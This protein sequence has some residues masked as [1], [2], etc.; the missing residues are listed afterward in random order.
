MR[1]ILIIIAVLCIFA[2]GWYANFAF[3][4]SNLEIP[5]SVN[6]SEQPSPK[7]RISED[8]IR[9]LEDKIIINV[10]NAFWASYADS[11]SMDPLLDT[12]AN[13]LEL[14]P[15]SKEDLQVGDVIAYQTDYGLIVHRII[16]INQDEQ[17]WYCITKGDNATITDQQKIRF[18][19]VRFVL[20]GVIY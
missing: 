3:S 19:Q 2:F 10:P 14:I 7:D 12:E 20:I 8:Q 5:F 16:E 18:E 11:N 6:A 9:V 4:N 13:G 1:Q 15:E 17:G